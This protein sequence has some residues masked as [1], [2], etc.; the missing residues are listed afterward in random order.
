L[1]LKTK[2]RP[3]DGCALAQRLGDLQLDRHWPVD[4]E[5]LTLL[6][7]RVEKLAEIL[8]RHGRTPLFLGTRGKLSPKPARHQNPPRLSKSTERPSTADRRTR[9]DGHRQRH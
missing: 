1:F 8:K 5:Q 6:A 9:Q 7:E 3:G 4:V 2:G